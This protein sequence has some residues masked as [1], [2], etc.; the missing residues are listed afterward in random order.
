MATFYTAPGY[1]KFKAFCAE[2]EID[3]QREQIDPII[4][5]ETLVVSDDE[6][7]ESKNGSYN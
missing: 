1:R 6:E 2:A 3:Y 5:N 4:T 7:T